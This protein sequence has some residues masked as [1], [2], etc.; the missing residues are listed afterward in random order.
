MLNW[1]SLLPT[2]PPLSFPPPR[3][4]ASYS[5][6]ACLLRLCIH[7]VK[8][9]TVAVAAAGARCQSLPNQPPPC[10]PG[11]PAHPPRP[12][13]PPA[14]TQLIGGSQA[15]APQPESL[16]A[17]CVAGGY[18]PHKDPIIAVVAA[19]AA[20][21]WAIWKG[22]S[23]SLQK[24]LLFLILCHT[25]LGCLIVLC[26]FSGWNLTTHSSGWVNPMVNPMLVTPGDS[27]CF[28]TL[29]HSFTTGSHWH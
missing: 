12:P 28:I 17:F 25:L 3:H 29:C 8:H 7:S 10:C 4:V 26:P 14:I 16:G 15:P 20:I 9:R 2:P 13:V 22:I 11:R 1:I 24:N 19:M 5:P 18:S 6:A 23:N 27:C 21:C